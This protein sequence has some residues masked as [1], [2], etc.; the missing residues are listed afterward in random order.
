MA[1]TLSRQPNKSSFSTCDSLSPPP[2]ETDPEP[3]LLDHFAVIYRYRRVALSVFLLVVVL[4]SLPAYTATPTFQAAA[5]LSIELD[6]QRTIATSQSVNGTITA[7]WQD[8]KIYYETQN[9]IITGTALATRVVRRL[10]VGRVRE[11][12]TDGV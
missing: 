4:A 11:F 6:E 10:A 8:P 2:V 7:Y 9:R 3:R 12:M 5:R 1:A